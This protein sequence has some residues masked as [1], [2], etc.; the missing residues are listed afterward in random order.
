MTLAQRLSPKLTLFLY[1]AGMNEEYPHK[2]Y[3]PQIKLF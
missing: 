3:I 2:K 1:C